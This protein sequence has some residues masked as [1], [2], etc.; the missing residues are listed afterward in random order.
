MEAITKLPAPTTVREARGFLG[1]C[2]YYRRFIPNFSKIAEQLIDLTRKYARFKW[3]PCCQ[4]AFNFL[5]ESLTV[6]PLLA[7]PNTNKPYILYTDASNNCIGACLTQKTDEGE[8]KPIYYLFHKLSKTQVKWSTIEK[9]ACVIHYALQKLGHYLHS[10]QFTIRTDH[11]PLKYIGLFG[12]WSQDGMRT[13]SQ[14][15]V[16]TMIKTMRYP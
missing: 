11:K 2:S 9:E 4:E 6:V 1:M 8:D 15:K 10:A 7:Y 16:N 3:T 13:L 14:N 12:A 5:K